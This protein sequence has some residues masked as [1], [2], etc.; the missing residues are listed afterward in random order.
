VKKITCKTEFGSID[1]PDS[2]DSILKSLEAVNIDVQYHCREGFCGAC[3]CHLQAG[4]VEYT[5]DPLAFIQDDEFLPC[6]S[7]PL[8]DIKIDLTR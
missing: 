6:C 5:I 2:G 3:R 1:V 8:T 7:T 4:S